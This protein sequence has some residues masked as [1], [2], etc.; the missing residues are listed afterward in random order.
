MANQT[1]DAVV[2][3][4]GPAGTCSAIAL[5]RAGAKVVLIDAGARG[6]D[7]CCGHCL[8]GGAWTA[9]EEL[10]VRDVVESSASGVTRQ[11][12]WRSGTRGFE[13]KLPHSG[14]LVPR[15]LLD[16][17]LQEEA[18][19]VGVRVIQSAT[20]R[21]HSKGLIGVRQKCEEHFVE[22]RL[23]VA[24]DGLGSG[25]ARARGWSPARPGRKYGFA[26]SWRAPR[27]LLPW[28]DGRIEMRVARGGYLGIVAESR[29][30]IH[31]AGMIDRTSGVSRPDELL[32]EVAR[33][34]PL[35]AQA[36]DEGRPDRWIA[37]G[38][39]PWRPTRVA[40]ESTALVGDAAGYA[41]P[42]S[43]EG[44]RWAFEC[45]GGLARAWREEGGWTPRAAQQYAHWHRARIARRQRG[46]LQAAWLLRNP[47]RA[48]L[49]CRAAKRFPGVASWLA[50]SMTR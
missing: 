50:G 27:A 37:A 4:G 29:E 20:A 8:S 49:T 15:S 23:V 19:R 43:G 30:R 39:L 38:P 33:S 10:G 34:W 14:I 36:I 26:G 6:R 44:M 7:K 25:I 2:V 1:V 41:E 18:E 32:I 16:A 46:T 12:A 35:L 42:Y 5:A 17:G 9:L 13:M 40:D 48:A 47:A 22:A 28:P 45:A 11:V 3:G 21:W 31:V 24:A